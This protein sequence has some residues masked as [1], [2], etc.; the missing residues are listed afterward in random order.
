MMNK[1]Q[2]A[3][4][5]PI[6][7]IIEEARNGKM[8]ILVDDPDRENEGDLIVPAQMATPNAINFMAKYGRGLICLS[9][10]KERIEELSLPLMN[11]SNQKNDLTAFT[12]SI[13]AK[14]GVTTGISA[15]E[16]SHTI[17]VAINNNRNKDDLVSPGHVFP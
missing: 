10:T 4:I 16:R 15:A 13:E 6:E 2:T 1:V 8:Y 12:I 14:E 7:E 3:K 5:S 17:S 9:M 11:P